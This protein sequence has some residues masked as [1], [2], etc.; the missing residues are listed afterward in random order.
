MSCQ[1]GRSPPWSIHHNQC[2]VPLPAYLLQPAM[3]TM[4]TG[5]GT[6]PIRLSASNLPVPRWFQESTSLALQSMTPK[7]TDVVLASWPKSGTHWVYRAIRLLSLGAAHPDKPMTLAEMLPHERPSDPLP[8]APWNPT[9][10]DSFSDLLGREPEPRVIVSHALPDMLPPLESS[11]AGKL[12]Y[13]SRDPRDVV[14][15]NFFFMGQPRDGWDG[16]MNRFLA[17]NE[18][19]PN[20]FGGWFE[21]VLAFEQMTRRLGPTR[22]CVIEYEEMHSDLP[23]C[24]ARLAKL[25][26]PEAEA[27]LTREGDAIARA[28]GFDVMV[29]GASAHILRKGV[30]GGWREHFSAS[31]ERRLM[32]AIAERLPRTTESLVGLDTWRA[33]APIV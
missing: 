32:A 2:V 20:A 7:P 10:L 19:T 4:L 24:L 16:S 29:E 26:G 30:S 11:G 22:A 1:A 31:D 6:V 3:P 15:S 5:A 33:N 25:L 27:T 8:P 17:S 14:T 13:V 28:L 18:D 9:G 21:H 23:G 12:V